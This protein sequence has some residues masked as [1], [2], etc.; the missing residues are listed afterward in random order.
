MKPLHCCS[1]ICCLLAAGIVFAGDNSVE[2]EIDLTSGFDSNPLQMPVNEP[3][4]MFLEAKL[5]ANMDREIAS[6]VSMFFDLSTTLQRYESNVSDADTSRGDLK[7]GFEFVPYRNRQKRIKLQ[8]GGRLVVNRE[9][10]T[11]RS[12]GTVFS[13]SDGLG[14][15]VEIPDRFDSNRTEGFF[16]VEWRLNYRMRLSLDTTYIDKNYT[17]DYSSLSTVESLDYNSFGFEPKFRVDLTDSLDLKASVEVVDREYDTRTALDLTGISVPGSVREYD[18]VTYSLAVYYR[19][20]AVWALSGGVSLS[21]REDV[22]AGYYN[23]DELSYYG[24]FRTK[25]GQ[26][27]QL[28]TRVSVNDRDYVR[29][30]VNGE[31][32]GEIRENNNVRVKSS[33]SR[34]L[35]QNL[36]LTVEAV[37]YEVKSRN[38]LYEYDRNQLGVWVT[39]N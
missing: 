35:T 25:I 2:F 17:E 26:R 18:D 14:G 23:Y 13:V 22:Y 8:V 30:I 19:P 20:K 11:S 28:R 1:M 6:G 10:F 36:S 15:Q 34:T 31:I 12:S 32:N 27:N 9:I 29:A 21:D 16:D 39:F 33:F 24:T 3:D 5:G 37:F 4:G 7:A 38:A